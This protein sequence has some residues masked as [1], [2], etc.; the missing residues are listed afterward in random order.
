[1]GKKYRIGFVGCGNMGSA[2]MK[3]ILTAG[4]ADK[5]EI[6]ASCHTETS[7]ARL[8]E[9]YGIDVTTNN[10]DAVDADV[11]FLAVKPVK[12]AEVAAEIK[13]SIHPD[14]VLISVVAAKS[15]ATLEELFTTPEN[16]GKLQLVR[17]MPNTPA[18]VLEGMTAIT[19]NSTIT[20]AHLNYVCRRRLFRRI[21]W[22]QLQVSVDL[23]QPLSIC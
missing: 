18:M 10:K 19:P 17:T 2:M 13:D 3:G 8:E 9:T 4:L 7:K 1:M 22:M 21:S 23:H 20:E 16:A 14:T 6:I 5:D 15:I 12:L 11:V